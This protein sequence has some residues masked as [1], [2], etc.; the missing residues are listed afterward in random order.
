MVSDWVWK[1]RKKSQNYP[2]G[3]S[4]AD[5]IVSNNILLRY[6]T[7]KEHISMGLVVGVGNWKKESKKLI[8]LH[9]NKNYLIF[10]HC[11][12]SPWLKKYWNEGMNE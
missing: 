7:Q 5:C 8:K 2:L 11:S 9:E 10:H 12:P 3:F 6:K 4:L 1:Y